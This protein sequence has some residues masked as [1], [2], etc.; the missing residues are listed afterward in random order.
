MSVRWSRCGL[1]WILPREGGRTR[2]SRSI[3]NAIGLRCK[4]TSK[5]KATSIMLFGQ[6][7]LVLAARIC[8]SCVLHQFRQP[9]AARLARWR[10]CLLLWS[11][12]GVKRTW[13]GALHMS[14]FD[15][16]RTLTV[17][18]LPGHGKASV[19]LRLDFE[20]L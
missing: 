3:T 2:T 20:G 12:M 7:A 14:A 8:R 5:R 18:A 19:C 4:R 9:C 16:K 11:L 1:S 15:P 13:V 6:L 17:L 10:E